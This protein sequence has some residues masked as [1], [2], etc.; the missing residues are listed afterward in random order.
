[1]RTLPDPGDPTPSQLEDHR[2]NGHV[3]Y[4]SWCRACVEGRSTG[5]QHRRRDGPRDICVFSFDYLFLDKDGRSVR[6]R[7]E[8][9]VDEPETEAHV[10]ILVAK[11]S[12]G[13]AVFAHVVPQKGIDA[14]NYA[15]QA[16]LRDIQ[17]LGYQR[18]S[19]RS[20]NEAA[21]LRLLKNTATE[22]RLEVKDLQQ[23][24]EEH[25][26]TYDS[27][28]NGEIEATVKQLTGILRTN[29]IDL[30]MRLGKRIPQNHP[31]FSW[32]VEY[33]SWVIN[34]KV[35][36]ADGI[37]AYQRV[38]GRAPAKRLVPF[39]ETVLVHLPPKGPER[40]AGGALGPRV[41]EGVCIGYGKQSHSYVVFSEG[42]VGLYR[43][44]QRLPLS[45]RW[46]ADK[47]Q[48]VNVSVEDANA[49]PGGFH[50]RTVPLTDR[51]PAE[52]PELE[53]PKSR[54]AR[55]LELRQADFDPAMQGYGWSENC[56][57]C[58][59]ARA[60]GWRASANQQHSESCRLRIEAELAKTAKGRARLENAKERLDHW[61]AKRGEEIIG[62]Q[63]PVQPEG[64]M[65]VPRHDDDPPKFLPAGSSGGGSSGGGT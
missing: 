61:A 45:T 5:E 16:L 8:G 65:D 52:Q 24:T 10:K 30:E 26:N 31:V 25:P 1:M 60:Y 17:W 22:A 7:G 64:E 3:P 46:S 4:R 37:T 62:Q 40:A 11:D 49:R 34:I 50:A 44:M 42:T 29:K 36:G 2:A 13:K 28:G 56:P 58:D 23:L 55:R 35:P 6:K 14:N 18:I 9:D 47:V 33:A 43:S 53:A 12:L 57:K 48:A 41:K 27:A 51:D 19:L 20:D 15:V 39:G 54:M 59:K 63:E 38:R 32:L 21:I